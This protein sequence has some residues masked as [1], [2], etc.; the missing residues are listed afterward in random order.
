[1]LSTLLS[2][3]DT[4]QTSDRSGFQSIPP[5][6]HLPQMVTCVSAV[7]YN[8]QIPLKIKKRG[9]EGK[10]IPSRRKIKAEALDYNRPPSSCPFFP[11]YITVVNITVLPI[12]LLCS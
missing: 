11:D 10:D 12:V 5:H 3:P 9:E 7:K 8:V 2:A 4:G 6:T 1:M